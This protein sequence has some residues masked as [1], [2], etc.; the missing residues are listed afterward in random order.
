MA[1]QTSIPA[2]KTS[3]LSIYLHGGGCDLKKKKK[4]SE[5]VP[6]VSGGPILKRRLIN[7][8][9]KTLKMQCICP[10]TT[11]RELLIKW[12]SLEKKGIN[13]WIFELIVSLCYGSALC[14]LYWHMVG[15]QSTSKLHLFFQT[16][17]WGR[18]YCPYFTCEKWDSESVSDLSE[19]YTATKWRTQT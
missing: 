1:T 19:D 9:L 5:K 18:F 10:Q 12:P 2:Y 7:G 13:Y 8:V 15:M 16:I 11:P 3:F 6:W 17:L 14:S 4:K